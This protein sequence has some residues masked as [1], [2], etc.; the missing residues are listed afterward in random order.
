MRAVERWQAD[1]AAATPL[2]NGSAVGARSAATLFGVAWAPL[3]DQI[4]A[5]HVAQVDREG[6]GVA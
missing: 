5:L 2:P 1:P 3:L 4:K 6:R